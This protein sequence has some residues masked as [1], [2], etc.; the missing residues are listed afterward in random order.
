MSATSNDASA[1]PSNTTTDDVLTNI[2]T[3]RSLAQCGSLLTRSQ[4][5]KLGKNE[6]IDYLF[7]RDTLS[8]ALSSLA[9][10]FDQLTKRLD[11]SEATVAILKSCNQQLTAKCTTLEKRLTAIERTSTNSAQYLRRRQIE[12]KNIPEHSRSNG[13]NLKGRMSSLLSLTGETVSPS[14]LDKCHTLGKGVIMEFVSREK[15]DAVLRGRKNFKNKSQELKSLKMDKPM[16]VESLCKSYGELDFICRTLFRTKSIAKT[17]FFNGRL[18]IE[19][20]PGDR[21]EISH[22]TDLHAIFGVGT[23]DGILGRK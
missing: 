20:E 3:I 18:H 22:I 13:P 17:W 11:H 5:E 8:E 23:I 15:R 10:A 1:A 12:V 21:R 7:K 4:V 9:G 19:L 2:E 14:D 6:V 16:V